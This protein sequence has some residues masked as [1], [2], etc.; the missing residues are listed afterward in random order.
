MFCPGPSLEEDEQGLV[1]KPHAF[2]L[3]T[4]ASRLKK[5]VRLV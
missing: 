2:C 3:N 4:E 5:V 1:P